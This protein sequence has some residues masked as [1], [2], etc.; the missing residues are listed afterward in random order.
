QA[1]ADRY[2][3]LPL[4]G[5]FL[6]GVWLVADL[7]DRLRVPW[8]VRALAAV[9]ALAVFGVLSVIQL[10]HWRSSTT[11]FAHALAVTDGNLVA[12]N[13]LGNEL[14]ES[15]HRRESSEQ[16]RAALSIFPAHGL[17]H[18]NLGQNLVAEGRLS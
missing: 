10:G 16:Y 18:F 9:L 6:A 1:R 17:A 5:I 2:T 13:A 4:I 15:G 7:S 12:H 8:A 3:Y 11:L 14:A